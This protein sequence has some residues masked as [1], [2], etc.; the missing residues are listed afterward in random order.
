MND[1]CSK[2]RK[3]KKLT[4]IK[5][6]KHNEL[7]EITER[8]QGMICPPILIPEALNCSGRGVCVSESLCSCESG[9]TG[10]GD[11]AFGAPT[12]SI[13]IIAVKVLWA[14]TSALHFLE[15]FYSLSFVVRKY[16]AKRRLFLS[17]FVG[18][19]ALLTNICFFIVGLTRAVD[20]D[21]RV[22]GSD[23]FITI[24][25]SFG[26][27]TFWW[28]AHVFTFIFIELVITQSRIWVKD[29]GKTIQTL[30]QMKLGLSFSSLVST[31][32]CILPIGMLG[33]KTA[34]LTQS[35]ATT[36]Y[37]LLAG[38]MVVTGFFMI[39]RFARMVLSAIN[40]T[41]KCFPGK[42]QK[43]ERMAQK[44]NKF[45]K[46]L[47]NQALMNISTAL[48]F[49]FWPLLQIAGSSYFLPFAWSTVAFTIAIGLH[50]ISPA[51]DNDSSANDS[52]KTNNFSS[53]QLVPDTFSSNNQHAQEPFNAPEYPS[54]STS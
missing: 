2:R 8:M 43:L 26:A 20:T 41:T 54:F 32:A 25:F 35:L 12:C 13:N 22:I 45:I 34:Y 7:N 29:G 49:G 23:P 14:I 11:F 9:W 1:F 38:G 52:Q 31:I 18:I 37:V 53:N 19:L 15:I 50:T 3:Q 5:Q 6:K 44:L 4:T 40:D 39:P 24:L 10:R 51:K 42:N 17:I 21:S 48:I 33:A 46:E 27:M 28:T 16:R 47:R 30:K 36:H